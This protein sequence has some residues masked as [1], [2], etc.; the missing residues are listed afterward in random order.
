MVTSNL[1]PF[2][3]QGRASTSPSPLG[4]ARSLAGGQ[5]LVTPLMGAD[6]QVRGC[7][8]HSLSAVS[9]RPANLVRR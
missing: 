9:Q 5:L 8:G 7:A 6:Q 2:A 3:S 1:P 4:D